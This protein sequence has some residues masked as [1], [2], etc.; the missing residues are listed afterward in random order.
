LN[1]KKKSGDSRRCFECGSL[2]HIR[3]KCIK[4]LAR[5]ARDD[6]D[7]EEEIDTSDKKKH[8]LR[9]NKKKSYL[10]RKVVHCVLSALDQV[11]LSDVDMDSEDDTPKG[12]KFFI[13]LC[14][15]ASNKSSINSDIHSD[16]EGNQSE[17]S[18]DDLAC[19]IEKL[20]ALEEKRN[21]KIK[22]HDVLIE[23]LCNTPGVCH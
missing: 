17:P 20:G 6:E 10:N 19:A 15:I 23:P 4:Y 11:N 16:N 14:L 8:T 13:G 9:N 18:Y 5:I 7:E 3:L 22:K 12:K 21:K 1:K 2:K